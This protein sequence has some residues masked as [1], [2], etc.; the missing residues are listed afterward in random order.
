MHLFLYVN[1]CAPLVSVYQKRFNSIPNITPCV[2]YFYLSISACIYNVFECFRFS[3]DANSG[4]ISF[5]VDYNIDNG[6]MPSSVILTVVC[7][8]T[9]SKTGTSKV[10][11]TITVR[12]SIGTMKNNRIIENSN[13][14]F[15]PN[16]FESFL[17]LEKKSYTNRP[18]SL[19]VLIYF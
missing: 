8:D 1:T 7:T 5:A 10:E 11:V 16:E 9:T 2:I 4:I 19:V 18:Y 6:A 15:A 12:N 17:D 14:S 3:I 13:Q